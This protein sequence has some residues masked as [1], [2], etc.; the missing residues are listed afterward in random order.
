MCAAATAS[1]AP[2]G[3]GPRVPPPRDRSACAG[4]NRLDQWDPF[5]SSISTPSR[6]NPRSTGFSAGSGEPATSA[7]PLAPEAP[8]DGTASSGPG[9]SEPAVG[10][11]PSICRP[12]AWRPLWTGSCSGSE[13]LMR[14][15]W[16]TCGRR[17]SRPTPTAPR[18][19]RIGRPERLSSLATA[20]LRRGSHP[21]R[22]LAA[23]GAASRSALPR[24]TPA[25][26]RRRCHDEAFHGRAQCWALAIPHLRRRG[27]RGPARSPRRSVLGPK[28]RRGVVPA[29]RR[30][31]GRRGSEGRGRPGIRGGDRPPSHGLRGNRLGRGAATRGKQVVAWA[32]EGDVDVSGATSNT[33]EL[34]WPRGSGRMQAFPEV[35]RVEWMSVRRARTKLLR[36]QLPFL[37]R[38]LAVATEGGGASGHRRPES[39]AGGERSRF[40]REDGSAAGRDPKLHRPFCH[41]PVLSAL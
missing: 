4:G 35:D 27:A 2:R 36:G 6:C 10:V 1:S 11:A 20:V 28:G 30:V 18:W 22:S 38:L 40:F 12:S 31:R 9:A 34:E 25:Y 29:E 7:V 32:V 21:V 33:F 15:V 3:R 26:P 5:A 16:L 24:R 13:G 8:A 39:V 17:L 23:M 41:R 19:L 14:S 37:D